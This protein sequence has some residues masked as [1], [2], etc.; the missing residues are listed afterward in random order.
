MKQCQ[1]L[2][3]TKTVNASAKITDLV[4]GGYCFNVISLH[5]EKNFEK[6][7]HDTLKN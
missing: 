6:E 2:Y 5:S 1:L 4:L 3:T 7:N